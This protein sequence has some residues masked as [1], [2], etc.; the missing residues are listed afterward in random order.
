M[1][2]SSFDLRAVKASEVSM[3]NRAELDALWKELVGGASFPSTDV[4]KRHLRELLELREERGRLM[5]KL[6]KLEQPRPSRKRPAARAV[7]E[8]FDD[9]EPV[10][11]KPPMAEPAPVGQAW[12]GPGEVPSPAVASRPPVNKVTPQEPSTPA[13][14]GDTPSNGVKEVDVSGGNRNTFGPNVKGRKI[15][16][17]KQG[18]DGTVEQLLHWGDRKS[19]RKLDKDLECKVEGSTEWIVKEAM[20]RLVC[21]TGEVVYD[22]HTATGGMRP[23]ITWPGQVIKKLNA[24]KL[25]GEE[26]D[27][28]LAA[29]M[30]DIQKSGKINLAYV[31]GDEL[32]IIAGHPGGWMEPYRSQH[33]IDFEANGKT[34]KRTKDL[35]RGFPMT[36][37][38][39]PGDLD[40]AWIEDLGATGPKKLYDGVGAIGQELFELLVE[41]IKPETYDVKKASSVRADG[42]IRTLSPSEWKEREEKRVRRQ[43]ARMWRCRTFNGRIYV[44]DGT[45]GVEGKGRLLKGNWIVRKDMPGSVQVLAHKVNLKKELKNCNKW[46]IGM[47]DQPWVP[48]VRTNIQQATS[49]PQLFKPE[50]WKRWVDQEVRRVVYYIT[51]GEDEGGWLDDMDEMLCSWT[52]N[53]QG[54][55]DAGLMAARFQALELLDLGYDLTNSPAL[56]ERLFDAHT[57]KLAY[58]RGEKIR[59]KIPV[60]CA[61]HVQIISHSAAVQFGQ[62]NVEVAKGQLRFLKDLGVAV[63]HDDDWLEMIQ[64][65]GGCDQ[66]DLFDLY[67]RTVQG[68][69]VVIVLRNPSEVRNWSCFEYVEGDAYPTADDYQ[70]VKEGD[71]DLKLKKGGTGSFP[72]A[73][74]TG[75]LE[76]VSRSGIKYDSPPRGQAKGF[77]GSYTKDELLKSLKRWLHGGNPGSAI[78]LCILWAMHFPQED[79]P[80]LRYP[81]E[82]IIDSHVQ[83]DDLSVIVAMEK[84]KKDLQDA[85]VRK[86]KETGV[87]VDRFYWDSISMKAEEGIRFGKG[88]VSEMWEYVQRRIEIAGRPK[89]EE[90]K[91]K[92]F[93]YSVA[94]W[95]QANHEIPTELLVSSQCRYTSERN[96]FVKI[97]KEF[98]RESVESI[99]AQAKMDP[100]EAE[101]ARIAL[102]TKYLEIVGE[103]NVGKFALVVHSEPT[104]VSKEIKDGLL[105]TTTWWPHYKK[106]LAPCNE[107]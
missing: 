33:G 10:P 25:K 38:L 84:E 82:K 32:T 88:W 18:G 53:V 29:V 48:H 34:H 13:G 96:K 98:R 64:N 79:R 9:A 55:D 27:L 68:K 97:L 95:A 28:L 35:G 49:L 52:F 60:P 66:D 6:R 87:V 8:D 44:P 103:E 101:A 89:R 5:D 23:M 30:E 92:F 83:E 99:R 61:W 40:L 3:L 41:S 77:S 71:E 94:G 15:L 76:P 12:F 4:A 80:H 69:K 37:E 17:R 78:N 85:F 20:E 86:A 63:V 21:P 58:R 62:A 14:S 107:C 43:K 102:Y 22:E 2:H 31:A 57:K 73:E 93:K 104:A 47:Q 39:E 91:E 74:L 100:K 50:D 75:A 54:P 51:A 19:L 42:T 56:A 36:V 81:L 24:G 106:F 16:V 72:P 1:N 26:G 45:P 67:Y 59:I 70:W 90:D 7:D 11:V 105:M 65:H 46:I